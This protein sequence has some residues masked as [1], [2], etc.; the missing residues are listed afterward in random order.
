V[1]WAW[2]LAPIPKKAKEK[3]QLGNW[4]LGLFYAHSIPLLLPFDAVSGSLRNQA[5]INQF[6]DSGRSIKPE[7]ILLDRRNSRSHRV[8]KLFA[9]LV[10]T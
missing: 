6:I 8:I 3:R 1:S 4:K 9:S 5:Y 2:V 7:S 10:P